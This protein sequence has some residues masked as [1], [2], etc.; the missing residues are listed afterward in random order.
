[1]TLRADLLRTVLIQGLGAAALL[2]ASAGVRCLAMLP[3]QASCANSAKR[4]P[5]MFV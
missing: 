3:R 1:M 4:R 5:K 2:A